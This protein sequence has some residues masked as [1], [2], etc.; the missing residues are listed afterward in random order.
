MCCG[1]LPRRF[2]IPKMHHDLREHSPRSTPPSD[3]GAS[4]PGRPGGEASG[5]ALDYIRGDINI[6]RL[7]ADRPCPVIVSCRRKVDGGNWEGTE[8]QRQ[9]LLRLAIAEGVEYLDME[10]DI[11]GAIPRFGQTKRIV[12]LHD[13]R[14]TPD[15]LGEI[16]KRLC[17][18]SPD[19][20]K[21]CTMANRPHDNLRM[22]R[23]VRDAK[24][25]TVGICMGDI[26]IPSRLLCGKYGS[27]FTYA[28]FHHGHL[29]TGQLTLEQMTE[30]YHYDQIGPATEVYGVV[31]DP[32][33]HSLGPQIHNAAFY[34]AKLDKVYLPFRVPKEDLPQFVDEACELDIKGL[35]VTIPHK[36]AVI[37][38]LTKV[39]GA[40][41]GIGAANTVV[42]NGAERVGYNTDYRAAMES[43]EAAMEGAGKEVS[44]LRGKLVLILGAGGVGKA[45]AYGLLRRG[46]ELSLP[47]A[48]T[49]GP[50]NSAR[51]L[52]AS[53]FSGRLAIPSWPTCWPTAPRLACTPTWTRRLFPRGV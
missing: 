30:V 19:V 43:I 50:R 35:S 14:M 52:S 20:I 49:S 5:I 6:K 40:V 7:I 45:I 16:Y 17:G 34:A 48:L 11:A 47:T 38:K 42:F 2:L 26:G 44:P 10:E 41:R 32:V 29:A 12:S 31:A 46:A 28:T 13:F 24:V 53:S 22:L 4:P 1:R 25:P 39:N 9:V 8:E 3:C 21:I 18:L 27:P 36:E 37:E 51:G 23:M 15:D 33:G